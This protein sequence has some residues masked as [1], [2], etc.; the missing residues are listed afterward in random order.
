MSGAGCPRID[1]PGVTGPRPLWS[2]VIP[3]YHPSLSDLERALRS[4]LDAGYGPGEMQ[5]EIVDDGSTDFVPGEFLR[6]IGATDRVTFFQAPSHQ[7]IGQ[8][9][10]TGLARS[11]G[12]WVHILHQD[13]HVLPGF[14]QRLEV[15]IRNA[16]E[17]GAACTQAYL[18]D[19]HAG[20]KRVRGPRSTQQGVL[21][22]WVEDIFVQL[23]IVAP[24]MV[25]RRSVYEELGGFDTSF[26]YALDWDM[27][28]RIAIHYPVWFEPAPL[29]VHHE[30]D[31]S[32]TRRLLHDAENMREIRRSIEQSCAAFVEHLDPAVT[33]SARDAYT[34]FGVDTALKLLVYKRDVVGAY[35]QLHEACR[36]SAPSTVLRLM[37]QQSWHGVRARIGGEHASE[38][39]P[40]SDAA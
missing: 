7:G 16:L 37:L 23:T 38:R 11:V 1:P 39:L 18:I 8:N 27:W 19:E 30:H 24:A 35:R 6:E 33:L 15:G 34:R 5:V 26:R 9:W 2:V 17:V 36:L 14:Y 22:D 28:K 12:Q 20:K 25:V 31:S 10:N 13:D 32:A 4:V 29:V 21:T 40:G 3:T